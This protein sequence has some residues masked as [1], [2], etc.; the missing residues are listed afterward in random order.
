MW[1]CIAM[2]RMERNMRRSYMRLNMG[3]YF[4]GRARDAQQTLR[5]YRVNLAPLRFGA[6]LKGKVFDGFETGTPTVTTPI[7]A[8]GIADAAAWGCSISDDPQVFVSAAVQLYQDESAW[9]AVQDRASSILQRRFSS[10]VWMPRLPDLI[11]AARAG[12]QLNRHLHFTG[13]MLRHHHQRS[14]EF[15]S[16]WIEA[17]NRP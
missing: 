3:F 8:E 14:T 16:R 15:M 10:R 11:E 2:A 7:G 17:K 4:K 5:Q 12:L 9:R 6:G 1:S 13:R